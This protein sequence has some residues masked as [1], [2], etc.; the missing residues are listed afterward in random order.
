MPFT[1]LRPGRSLNEGIRVDL[2]RSEVLRKS[3]EEQV[4]IKAESYDKMIVRRVVLITTCVLLALILAL[5]YYFMKMR[6]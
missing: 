3:P 4:A 5:L 2:T 6:S 1:Q